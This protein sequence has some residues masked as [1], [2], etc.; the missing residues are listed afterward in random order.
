MAYG[1]FPVPGGA[2][3]RVFMFDRGVAETCAIRTSQPFTMG[4]F[5]WE[6]SSTEVLGTC[7]FQARGDG[8]YALVKDWTMSIRTLRDLVRHGL[9]PAIGLRFAQ[10]DFFDRVDQLYFT[11]APEPGW[12]R[13]L[14]PLRTPA[15][16]RTEAAAAV[17][18]PPD[19]VEGVTT[20]L[21][22]VT[23]LIPPAQGQHTL[24][25]LPNGSLA[26]YVQLPGRWQSCVFDAGDSA[27]APGALASA[28]AHLVETSP[29]TTEEKRGS[30][31]S[32]DDL[33]QG[34]DLR[35][36][37]LAA[38]DPH[39]RDLQG[40]PDPSGS[41]VSVRV[42]GGGRALLLHDDAPLR[43]TVL[44]RDGSQ[45][46]GAPAGDTGVPCGDDRHEPRRVEDH[47]D[48]PGYVKVE[49]SSPA[50][51]AR[52]LVALVGS[53]AR[54]HARALLVALE[55]FAGS[56]GY[57]VQE[58]FTGANG[59]AVRALVLVAI[60][61]TVARHECTLPG[62]PPDHRPTVTDLVEYARALVYGAPEKPPEGEHPE[63]TARPV[64]GRALG[65]SDRSRCSICGNHGPKLMGW[66]ALASPDPDVGHWIYSCGAHDEQGPWQPI[67][68]APEAPN[69]TDEE[70]FALLD[71]LSERDAALRE[72]ERRNEDLRKQSAEANLGKTV[73][74]M[75]RAHGLRGQPTVD[76]LAR[77]L[78][79]N[80]GYWRELGRSPAEPPKEPGAAVGV[81]VRY[82]PP[83]VE[84]SD[85]GIVGPHGEA[86]E[87]FGLFAIPLGTCSAL[88]E[89]DG[90][91]DR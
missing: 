54:A 41:D 51:K 2:P 45:D 14:V 47:L 5:V 15:V 44:A 28:I 84:L 25:L 18:R 38:D 55:D 91:P 11:N 73:Q 50:Q 68:P 23:R 52:D 64:P 72:L 85:S 87:R 46:R 36:G 67:R 16:P 58:A 61:G 63:V 74:S 10:R 30:E 56:K 39:H 81:K 31:A 37:D 86:A 32:H 27:Q 20:L 17:T 57:R 65:Y 75:L 90:R 79:E 42:D 9:Y 22:V 89:A 88:Q 82:V 80:T 59:S 70:R 3:G 6:R 1:T 49:G 71:I 19:P 33:R 13:P 34:S 69:R 76:A 7:C 24:A 62:F 26:V 66:R 53:S 78:A 40:A 29:P 21:S 43:G 48:S 4:R 60:P 83:L 35:R 8:L 77:V 12:S